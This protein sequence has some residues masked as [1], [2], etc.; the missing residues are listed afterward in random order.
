MG[1][2][3]L[4]FGRLDSSGEERLLITNSSA[5]SRSGNGGAIDRDK[6]R[7]SPTAGIVKAA[8]EAVPCPYRWHQG[9]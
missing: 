9:A 4:P 8:G 7:A 6:A 2:L 3:D 1:K 5:S